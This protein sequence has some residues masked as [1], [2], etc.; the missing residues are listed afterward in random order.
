M[1]RCV[2]NSNNEIQTNHSIEAKR[3]GKE[4]KELVNEQI[5]P[6][7][8]TRVKKRKQNIGSC[9]RAKQLLNIKMIV[10]LVEVLKK[11]GEL[12]IRKRMKTIQ[13]TAMLNSVRIPR[14]IRHLMSF[15]LQQKPP[16]RAGVKDLPGGY[17]N[18]SPNLG[19]TNRPSDS[20]QKKRKP[21][22]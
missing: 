2:C 16:V 8:Q 6:F 4:R 19:Q 11:L 14:I 5:L 3:P 15:K 20:Q 7:Q 1:I 17:T 13:T 21:A 12:K 9:Q 22:E 18:R 10:V